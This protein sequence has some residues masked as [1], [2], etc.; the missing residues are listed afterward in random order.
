VWSCFGQGPQCINQHFEKGTG[1][2]QYQTTA[3]FA[4]NTA[5]IA[6]SNACGDL[7]EIDEAGSRHTLVIGIS[8]F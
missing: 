1:N 4:C 2:F 3:G 7:D 8:L 6:G 5:G